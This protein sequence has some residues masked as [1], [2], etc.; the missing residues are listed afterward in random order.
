MKTARDFLRLPSS[1]RPSPEIAARVSAAL[2][3]L[4]FRHGFRNLTVADLCSRAEIGE[5]DFERSY[6]DLDDAFAQVYEG[7]AQGFLLRIFARFDRSLTWRRQIRAAAEDFQRYLSEDHARAHF[8]V[9]D[10]NYAGER[11]RLVR[12]SVFAGLFAL[13][14]EG[15]FEMEDPDSL[16]PATAESVGGAIFRQ[17]RV[18]VEERRFEDL[19][20]M[21][22]NLMYSVVL[23]YLG[24]EAAAEELRIDLHGNA[25]APVPFVPS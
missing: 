6:R 12:D 19:E 4:C 17:I 18:T 7:L 2:P 14:D 1:R 5:S 20:G 13:I 22:S 23:P 15:R 25:P 10:C 11:A 21:V 3:T 24:P 16:T 9:V 8:T